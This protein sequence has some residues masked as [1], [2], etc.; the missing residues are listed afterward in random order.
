MNNKSDQITFSKMELLKFK[1]GICNRFS[2]I[3][4][5]KVKPFLGKIIE[6]KCGNPLCDIKL[7][8]KVPNR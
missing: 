1:C 2:V 7:N 4:A 6:L 3:K 5:V 8:I